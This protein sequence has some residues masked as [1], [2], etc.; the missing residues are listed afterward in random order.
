[1]GGGGISVINLAP[2]TVK[3]E[4]VTKLKERVHVFQ[5]ISQIIVAKVNFY[6]I[7]YF[8]EYFQFPI[9]S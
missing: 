2:L 1:M 3:K 7:K 8:N 5:D 4:N 9:T 6:V